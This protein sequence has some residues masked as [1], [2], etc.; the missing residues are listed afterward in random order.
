[1]PEVAGCGCGAGCWVGL[2]FVRTGGGDLAVVD[3]GCDSCGGGASDLTGSGGL[4]VAGACVLAAVLTPCCR[5]DLL[6]SVECGSSATLRPRRWVGSSGGGVGGA[7]FCA[8]AAPGAF[9]GYRIRRAAPPYA[10]LKCQCAIIISSIISAASMIWD[11]VNPNPR[12]RIVS[13]RSC[14]A[15]RAKASAASWKSPTVSALKGL[16]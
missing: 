2:S 13:Q 7:V 10:S 14:R 9:G 16:S 5:G 3:G 8:R 4:A 6:R 12:V 15:R 11:R 1:M